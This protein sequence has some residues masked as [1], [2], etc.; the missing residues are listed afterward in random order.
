MKN[1]TH[2]IKARDVVF[3]TINLHLQLKTAIFK[4]IDKVLEDK[5]AEL[6]WHIRGFDEA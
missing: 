3:E 4:E 1:K 6:D 2:L 5:L